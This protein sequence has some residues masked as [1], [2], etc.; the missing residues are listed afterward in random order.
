MADHILDV[1]DLHKSYGRQQVLQG[2]TC[3]VKRNEHCVLIGPSGGGKSTLLR[4]IM[5][6]EEI[7]SGKIEFKGQDYVYRSGKKTIISQKLKLQVGMVFQ[8][9][10][11][12]PHLTVLE[13]CTLGPVKVQKISEKE[14]VEKAKRILDSVGLHDKINEYPNRLSG[15]QRQRAAI[16][17]SL[18]MEPDLML[19]DEI[20]SALDPELIKGVLDILAEVASQGM[21]MLIIT[22]EMDFAISVSDNVIFL[23]EGKIIDSGTSDLIS[24]PKKERTKL[25][26][27]HFS[28]RLIE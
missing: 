15:G 19:F 3:S 16:A 4:C 2:V 27:D 7:D 13:N 1:K 10:N 14:A 12:F 9:Y 17:R 26:L 23:D 21:T 6:L 24:N 22:H 20:T 18:V 25:F 11:L 28:S 5:G 8:Q